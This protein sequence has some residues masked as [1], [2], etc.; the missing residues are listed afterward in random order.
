MTVESAVIQANPVEATDPAAPGAG[1]DSGREGHYRRLFRR[2]VFLTLFSSILPLLLIGWVINYYYTDFVLHRTQAAFKTQLEQHRK[3]VDQFL[4]EQIAKLTLVAQA[5]S[6]AFLAD[7]A[8]LLKI[9]E[10][11][12]EKS[13]AFT[14]LGLIDE[15][16]RHLAY[17]GPYDLID[18]NYANAFW[19]K[20]IATGYNKQVYVS[21]MFLGFREVPHFVIAVLRVENDRRWILRATIDTEVFRSVVEDVRIG[22][23]GEVF[24][25][26]REGVYQTNPSRHGRMMEKSLFPL[27]PYSEDVQILVQ[28]QQVEPGRE[29]VKQIAAFTWLEKPKWMLAIRQD[30]S[31]A[32]Y[33]VN[34]AQYVMLIFLHVSALVILVVTVLVARSMIRVIRRRDAEV[35]H[36]NEKFIQASKLASV[37]ELSAGVA[38]E[39]NNPLAVILTEKQILA[40]ME[41]Q[42]GE[43]EPG[44]RAQLLRSL[45][46][47]SD[48]VQRCKRLTHNLLRFSRRS[49]SVITHV[50]VN[51]LVKD[52][53]E[54][55]DRD[56]ATRGVKLIPKLDPGLPP[57]LTDSSQL[58]QVFLN[59]ITNAVDAHDG[60]PYGSVQAVTRPHAGGRGVEIEITDTGCGIPPE[61]IDKIFDPFFTTKAVGKGT[62]LGLSICYG[63]LKKLG[64]NMSVESEPGKGAVFTVFLPAEPPGEPRQDG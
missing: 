52:V 64:G 28:R 29:P 44:F 46:R 3:L 55:V 13:G 56:A 9:Y 19:F 43:M 14:D 49:E 31:D 38:H 16:G 15:S 54:L 35:D 22:S 34:H 39:I 23:T 53:V 59:L 30:Y 21:D 51:L 7:E 63:I 47:I 57:V 26:N 6:K 12:S 45:V 61:I 10:N 50:D 60:K 2:F 58:Q 4:Q 33:D 24:I 32:L 20:E 1:R 18:R 11:I 36:A 25:L 40:D 8:N 42:T 27:M 41:K 5:N 48:Q 17:I 62:G 37:G